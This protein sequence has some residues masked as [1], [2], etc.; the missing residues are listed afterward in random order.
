MERDILVEGT[1]IDWG[2]GSEGLFQPK[3]KWNHMA[4][5]GQVENL[6]QKINSKY[7]QKW[8]KEGLDYMY[9]LG[10]SPDSVSCWGLQETG[11]H[12]LCLSH[13]DTNGIAVSSLNLTILHPKHCSSSRSLKKG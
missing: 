4:L 7:L 9:T 8:R 11:G 5:L 1:Y 6:G 3:E 12:Y 2:R 10:L 13:S